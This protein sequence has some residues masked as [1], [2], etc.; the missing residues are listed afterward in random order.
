MPSV[1]LYNAQQ[2]NIAL[3]KVWD[4]CK[5]RL[6]AGHRLVLSV[7]EEKRSEPQ[8]RKFHAL[9]RDMARARVEWMG[10][11]RDEGQWKLLFV[12]GHAVAT[13]LGADMVPGL[14]GEFVNLRESTAQMPKARMSSL[15]EYATA[16][17]ATHRVPTVDDDAHEEQ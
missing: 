15:L 16:Y 11:P 7:K 8:S 2:G 9:C 6:I 1:T 17:A 13:K 3:R 14:E 12:S 4:W 10:K 5:P